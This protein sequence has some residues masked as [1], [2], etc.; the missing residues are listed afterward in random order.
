MTKIRDEDYAFLRKEYP[1]T[2]RIWY[3]MNQ[4]C[5]IPQKGYVD[6][7]VCD[8]WNI[9]VVEQQGFINF[10][11][12]M[13]PSE[14]DLTID[15]INPIGDYEPKNCRWVTT[16]VQNNNTK[17][18]HSDKGKAITQARKKLGLN[19]HTIYSRLKR[20]WTLEDAI[21]LPP[22]AIPYRNRKI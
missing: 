6:V 16:V 9:D 21:N 18:H 1:R 20:G 5:K 15:R 10:L 4:R 13:G 14:K 2:W 7:E 3:R 11:D 8:D 17:W 19:R 12:D 22:S